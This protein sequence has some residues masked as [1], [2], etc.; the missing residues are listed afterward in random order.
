LLTIGV[1][2]YN[3]KAGSKTA[4]APLMHKSAGVLLFLLTGCSTQTQI[5]EVHVDPATVCTVSGRVLFTGS[6]PKRV[7]IDMSANPACERRHASAPVLTE[8]VIVN[9][10]GTL[11]NTFIRVK[12]GLPSGRWPMPSEPAKLDQDGCVYTPHVLGIMTGQPLEISNSDPIN[13]NVHA[14]ASTNAAWN[15]SQ[16]P[17]AEKKF[18]QFEKQEI[19]FPVTCSV[20]PWMRGYIGVVDHPFF[21][22][23]GDDGTFTLKGLPPGNYTVE[24]IHETYGR[25][26]INVAVRPSERKEI[27]FTYAG[28]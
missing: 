18:K 1:R 22:V 5:Q 15:E 13:H 4:G 9:A 7:T 8:Q 21:A 26:E 23:T 28:E 11:R 25:K 10:N 24:A 19:L 6:A 17:R 3:V 20:H 27:Q 12:T 16:A 14:E 2:Q